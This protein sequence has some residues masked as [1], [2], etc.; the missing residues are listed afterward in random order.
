MKAIVVVDLQ[1]AFKIPE[2]LLERIAK[3]AQEFPLRVFT[4]FVNPTDSPFRRALDR[5]ACPPGA[6]E[7]QLLLAPRPGDVVLE[8]R[9]Y[10]LGPEHLETLRD[11]GVDEVLVCGADTD[12]CVLAVLFS[13]FDGGVRCEVDPS[14]CWSSSGLQ[15]QALALIREQFKTGEERPAESPSAVS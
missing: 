8:K 5:H 7:T 3:R 14:L 13:L 10:G 11:R 9:T 6:P 12:A 1:R 2:W 4:R 15:E